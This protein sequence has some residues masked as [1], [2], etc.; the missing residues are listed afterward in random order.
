MAF[1]VGAAL[2]GLPA[3]VLT[4]THTTAIDSVLGKYPRTLAGGA[5]SWTRA[6]GTV[7]RNNLRQVFRYWRLERT[8]VSLLVRRLRWYQNWPRHPWEHGA[9]IAAVFGTSRLDAAQ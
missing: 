5:M 2:S 9:V 8:S 7:R 4:G 1:V 6:D 3:L